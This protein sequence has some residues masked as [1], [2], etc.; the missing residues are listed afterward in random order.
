MCRNI[1]I[2][3]NFE[4]SAT[5][6]EIQ[7]AS[8][9]FIRKV[10]GYR[11]PSKANEVAF[12]TAV[13]E[14]STIV[15]SL[16]NRLVTERPSLDREVEATKVKGTHGEAFRRAR[17]SI[18]WHSALYQQ[19]SRVARRCYLFAALRCGRGRSGSSFT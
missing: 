9:Q 6:D 10:S 11:Q 4:P 12:G 18:R 7:A 8:L 15:E 13:A 16:M 14:V 3:F 5:A 19:R 2:L 17:L 1:K